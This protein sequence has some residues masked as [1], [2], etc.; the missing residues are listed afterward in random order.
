MKRRSDAVR[1][2]VSEG[3]PAATLTLELPW[4]QLYALEPVSLR[5]GLS[6]APTGWTYRWY[7]DGSPTAVSQ[8]DGHTMTG[9]RLSITAVSVSDGGQYQC[10]G[11]RG[12]KSF[13]SQRSDGLNLSISELLPR[14]SLSV[15]PPRVQHFT[16]SKV[17][18]KCGGP[19]GSAG[20]TVK[21]YTKGQVEPSCSSHRGETTADGC[22]IR[23]TSE[24]DSGVYWCQ[25]GAERS[26]AVTLRVT[27]E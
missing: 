3:R 14:V 2:T 23:Y 8:T 21:R 20:W 5:C 16:G 9:D 7:R 4:T 11:M 12:S 6:G 10:E 25:S 15:D 19:G 27:D 13:V 1:V 22:V 26:S 24:S 17:T 18:L